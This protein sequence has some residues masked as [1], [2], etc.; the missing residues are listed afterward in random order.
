MEL[1]LILIITLILCGLAYYFFKP[2]NPI[3]ETRFQ[4]PNNPQLYTQE[5]LWKTLNLQ[6]VNLHK[7]GE[8]AEASKVAEEALNQARGTLGPNHTQVAI[9]SN[10]LAAFYKSQGRF[11]ESEALYKQALSI[12][13]NN[14]GKEHIDTASCL[15][16]LGDLY[17]ATGKY[18]ESEEHYKLALDIFEKKFGKT[19][20]NLGTIL[21]N[22]IELYKKT[23]K[24]N[25]ILLIEERL[26]KIKST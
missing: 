13:I 14:L 22:M 12:W 2:K 25:K 3:A 23:D 24:T 20:P 16:N 9:I 5:N 21:E 11:V 10:N 18:V 19:H 26:K 4:L 7:A 15:N 6:L 17:F 1:F 8:F